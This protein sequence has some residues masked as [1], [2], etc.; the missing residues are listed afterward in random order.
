MIWIAIES[1]VFGFSV[2]CAVGAYW[3]VSY[4]SAQISILENS[5]R[6]CAKGALGW[7]VNAF[8]A[9]ELAKTFREGDME[10]FK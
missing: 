10:D 2:G 7:Y 8:R 5:M 4:I 1:M 9:Q 6:E 3:A